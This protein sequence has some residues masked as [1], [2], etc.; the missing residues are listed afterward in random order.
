MPLSVFATDYNQ[1]T[2]YKAFVKGDL[3]P[4]HDFIAEHSNISADSLPLLL[5]L[6]YNYL[7]W[8]SNQ[9]LNDNQFRLGMFKRHINKYEQSEHN[10]SDLL[11]FR[12]A[13]NVYSLSILEKTTLTNNL[14]A[15]T[16]A[17]DACKKNPGTR[18]LMH[19]GFIYFYVPS[20]AGGSKEKALLYLR[21][22]EKKYL[23]SKDDYNWNLLNTQQHIAQ[24]LIKLGRTNEAKTYIK[25][26][27]KQHP[28][29][30]FLQQ[31]LE[32]LE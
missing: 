16:F 13:A 25:R 4:W 17:N 9:K 12:S 18:A 24:C 32:D 3:T 30:V 10:E 31:M 19:R 26:I 15:L 7:A 22:A 29:F 6:E 5:D 21:Q 11:A 28:D 14:Q 20:Y 8:A 23:K 1:E 2:F 27:L